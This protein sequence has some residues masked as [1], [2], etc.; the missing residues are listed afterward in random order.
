MDIKEYHGYKVFDDGTIIGRNGRKLSQVLSGNLYRVSMYYDSAYHTAYV[1]KI[2]AELFVENPR[3]DE[4]TMVSHKDGNMTNNNASNL[5]WTA[6]CVTSKS[7]SKVEV[8][9][10]SPMGKKCIMKA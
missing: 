10:T 9:R 2:V 7:N 8:V 6:H 4:Y 3:P 1:H 5:I